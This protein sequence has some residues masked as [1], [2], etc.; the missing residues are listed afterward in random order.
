MLRRQSEGRI[1]NGRETVGRRNPLKSKV[2]ISILPIL[3]RWSVNPHSRGLTCSSVMQVT[4]PSRQ[5]QNRAG[6]VHIR[7]ATVSAIT[8]LWTRTQLA[9]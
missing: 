7:Q 4:G 1:E 8:T 3:H 6:G 9:G 5:A 2:N